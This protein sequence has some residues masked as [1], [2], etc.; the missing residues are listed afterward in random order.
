[1]NRKEYD[2]IMRLLNE[3]KIDELK[4]YLSERMYS[5]AT[6]SAKNALMSLI[7]D[8]CDK[9]YPSYHMR[10]DLKQGKVIKTYKGD[11]EKT[12]DGFII[13]HDGSNCFELYDE[14][15]LVPDIL[16]PLERSIDYGNQED[17]RKRLNAL[18]IYLSR[19]DETCKDKIY[20]TTWEDENI[21]AWSKDEKDEVIVPGNMY[22]VAE[23][24]LG[25]HVEEYLFNDR[26]GI[27]LRS[28]KGRALIMRKRT[29]YDEKN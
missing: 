10:V 1:M 15:L 12:D 16:D 29:K 20:W 22:L 28:P 25:K 21:I 24:L 19:L 11:Y 5:N 3:N 18:K 13:N 7:N 17:R 4:E 2:V 6:G 26:N 14:S 27:F 8:N 23:T 9:E